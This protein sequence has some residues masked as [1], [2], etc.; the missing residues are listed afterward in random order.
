MK[1]ILIITADSHSIIRFRLSLIQNFLARGYKVSVVAPKNIF[2]NILQREMNGLGVEVIFF[3]LSRTG[4]NMFKELIS[5]LEL[6]KIVKNY[7]P[8]IIISYLIKPVI[9]TGLI[10]RFFKKIRY[11]PLITGVGYGLYE[12]NF[13]KHKILKFFI[14]KLYKEGIKSSER[15]FFFNQDDKALFYELKIITKNKLS[16]IINGSGVNMSLYPFSHLPKKPVFLMISRLI[17][18]KGVREYVQA[19]RFVRS[20]FPNVV[21]QLAGSLDENPESIS[22]EELQ[23][24]IGQENIKYLGEIKSVQSI[25]KSCKFF[26]LPSYREG[27][28]RSTLEALSTG[29]PI[30]TTDVPGCRETVIHKKNGLLVQSRDYKSLANAMIQLL[31]ENDKNIKIMA[32]ESY[33]IAKKKF[34][35][36]KVNQ[37]MLDLMNL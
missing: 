8:N 36:G 13:I 27:L 31:K 5:L 32:R 9:Y 30:I 14:I 18:D 6:Y 19:A 34:E 20:L 17:V 15:I 2:S 3:K 21:F 1:H 11:F 7:K 33:L 28:P 26:V 29:R 4:L 37:S 23:S 25:L 12:K 10:L 35:V 22:K 16:A 24:W